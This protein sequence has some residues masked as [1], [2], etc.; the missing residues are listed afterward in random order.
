[1]PV[2]GIPVD[3]LMS[4]LDAPLERDALVER[5]QHLGCDVEGYAT[6]QR[7]SCARCGNIAE[8]TET[9][10][11]PVLCDRCGADYKAW[12][13]LRGE[14]GAS[15]V[16][17]M[18]L[19]AVRPDMFDPGGL[20]RVL[21]SY[22][23]E[24]G[25]AAK[26]R[27]G[28]AKLEVKVEAR[29][30]E[31]TSF[32]PEIACAVVRGM[33]M[34]E[35]II[36]TM[37]KLQENL[38]WALGR[39]RKRASIGVYD[40]STLSCDKPFAYRTVGPDE[41]SFVPLGY[42]PAASNSALT[43]ARI[44]AEHP[45]GVG[46]AR[47]LEPFS[48]YPLL[49]DG[50]GKVLS[51]PPIINS[52]DT[53]VTHET[54]DVFVD[55]TGTERRVVERTLNILVTSL[56]EL[57]RAATIERVRIT[58]EGDERAAC[59]TPDLT[60]QRVTVDP[61]VAAR[62]IGVELSSAEVETLL[63]RMGHVVERGGVGEEGMLHV[64]V[65]AYRN[66]VM[67]PVDL[68]EDVA[69][70]YGYHNIRPKLLETMTVGDELGRQRTMRVGRDAMCGLGYF[71]VMTLILSSPEQQYEALRL[72]VRDDCV[73]IDNPISVEQ[74]IIRTSL[75]PGLL[76]TLS[77]NTDH[78]LPQHVFEVGN[79]THVDVESETGAREQ[80]LLAASAIGPRVD[81]AHIRSTCEALLREYGYA[82]E[83][84]PLEAGDCAFF[85]DG[86]GAGVIGVRGGEKKRL[87]CLGEIH[88]EVLE[89][90]KLVQPVSIFEL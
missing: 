14:L 75:V 62:T 64:D 30:A 73:M 87:G 86:R 40:L 69:I 4:R 78:E 21:R 85:I 58:R 77:A 26:Y 52:E 8:T 74:T 10:D 68:V 11:P 54:R 70:A 53:R 60:P 18:E 66:D 25:S 89:R 71:E 13:E 19:L 7:F 41:L 55:V 61:Y 36:R 65:P 83:T 1:M 82:L 3:M 17:R 45:K 2:I 39:D 24:R 51:M 9:E 57:D 42:D 84:V 33:T 35:D 79:V 28:E 16:I 72:P 59:V 67:H 81:F 43:P 31:P 22:L 23:A 44:L 47:L 27:L 15:D 50:A 88:P 29:L 46:Y 37:M 38:H 56:V 34:D 90:F 12:P 49:C 20:A 6:V 48:R 80:C 5:L 76:D 32:R 63:G